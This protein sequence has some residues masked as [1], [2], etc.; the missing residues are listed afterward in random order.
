M[1]PVAITAA[2]AGAPGGGLTPL[3]GG[4]VR[5]RDPPNPARRHRGATSRRRTSTTRRA[6]AGLLVRGVP[7]PTDTGWVPVS[8][9]TTSWQDIRLKFPSDDPPAPAA[10]AA[11]GPV[12]VAHWQ[13]PVTV[14]GS[15][16]TLSGVIR[17]TP[18]PTAAAASPFTTPLMI[19]GAVLLLLVGAVLV[20]RTRRLR[21]GEAEESTPDALAGRRHVPDQTCSR[22]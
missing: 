16:Q 10:A 18:G 13:I 15:P 21:S 22:S 12:D 6:R 19:A 17:W 8:E 5:H 2:V 1:T 9:Q 14:D 4:R 7:V 20:R 3:R 11:T